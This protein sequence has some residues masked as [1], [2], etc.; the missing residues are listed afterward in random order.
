MLRSPEFGHSNDLIQSKK[1]PI[2]NGEEMGISI[3][4]IFRAFNFKSF[5]AIFK[6]LVHDYYS[7]P[8]LSVKNRG[9]EVLR[10]KAI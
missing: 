9:F 4:S 10:I 8:Y 3:Q 5:M 7:R 6:K 1:L 2:F